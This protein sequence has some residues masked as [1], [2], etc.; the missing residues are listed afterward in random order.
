[1]YGQGQGALLLRAAGIEVASNATIK[2]VAMHIRINGA[3]AA[4]WLCLQ[5]ESRLRDENTWGALVMTH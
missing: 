2:A 4:G 3:I 1:M 5:S